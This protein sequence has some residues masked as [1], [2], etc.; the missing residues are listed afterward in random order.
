[1]VGSSISW[2]VCSTRAGSSGVPGP[3]KRIPALAFAG[4]PRLH[5]GGVLGLRSN[6]VPAIL[7]RGEEVLTRGDPRHRANQGGEVKVIMN[8]TTPDVQGFR[9][10]QGEIAVQAS[11]AIGRAARNRP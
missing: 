4:A 2:V 1:M 9:R 5:D 6:E 3:T 8:I 11:T 10:S 7:Q